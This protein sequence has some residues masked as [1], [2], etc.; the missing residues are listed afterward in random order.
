MSTDLTT[1]PHAM[2]RRHFLKLAGAGALALAAP[3]IVRAQA[4]DDRVLKIGVVGCG[5]RGTGAVFNALKADPKVVLWAVADVFPEQ[6]EASLERVNQR[7]AER[8][9]VD[10]ARKFIGL[11]SYLKMADSDVDVVL[12]ASPPGFRPK[13]ME[14]MVE[15]GKHLFVEKPVAVDV[16]GVKSVL[17]S[18]KRAKAKGLSV[19]HG[20]C[21][22]FDAPVQEGY[23]KVI[24]GDF[25]RVVSV[26][27][28]FLST[29]P[30]VHQPVDA[31]PDGMGD[32][33][34]Q[35]RNWMAYDWLSGGC[36][37]EQG[38]HTADK[39][40][41]AMNNALPVAAVATG[42]R[43]AAD[44]PGNTFDN[45]SVSYEFEGQRF[46][47]VVSRQWN[48]TYGEITD[49]V[50]CTDATFV[51]PNRVMAMDPQGKRIWRAKAKRTNMYDETH[52]DLFSALREGRQIDHGEYVANMTMMALMGREAA[53]TGQ[54]ITWEQMWNSE[55]KLGPEKL[56]LDASFAPQPVAVPGT[57]EL[58]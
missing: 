14:A 1:S 49:R 57:Y 21:W 29:P 38:I 20:L 30:K 18:A 12:L 54:R 26:Y 7:Y 3:A 10:A 48:G 46:G 24:A 35:I 53:R 5:G 11:D 51:A 4:S 56:D 23:G 42:G 19:Q 52:V 13:H 44:D 15:A 47:Q 25:G 55:Q 27:G 33:E 22:R 43:T 39:L 45:Y 37:V 16:A 50:F 6:V 8:V 17:E 31:R 2:P 58:G 32:V 9:Q 36:L 28:T 40:S 41:W 34:W